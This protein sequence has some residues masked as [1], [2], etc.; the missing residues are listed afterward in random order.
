MYSDDYVNVVSTFNTQVEWDF[1]LAEQQ[2]K[3]CTNNEDYQVKETVRWCVD[4]DDDDR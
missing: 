3:T 4:D 2:Y 1:L